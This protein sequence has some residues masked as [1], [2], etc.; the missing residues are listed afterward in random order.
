MRR[1]AWFLAL[2][3][4]VAFAL[5]GPRPVQARADGL[6]PSDLMGAYCILDKVVLEPAENPVTAQLWGACAIANTN[7]WY[8]QPAARG[9]FYYSILKGPAG[10]GTKEQLVR[11]EWADL[12]SVAGTGEAVGF[13]RRYETVGRFRKA[14]EKPES[15]D[16]YPL[17]IGVV[18]MGNRTGV[19]EVRDVVAQLKAVPRGR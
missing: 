19:P 6:V 3:G 13:G 12:K 14:D 18:K 5:S 17:H 16:P 8:F 7:D 2:A 9:Y 15:P 11:N 10:P 4:V 1:R